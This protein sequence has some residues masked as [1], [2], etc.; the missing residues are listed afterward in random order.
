M[1]YHHC[2]CCDCRVPLLDEEEW[3]ML[4][5]YTENM[6]KKIR[7]YKAENGCGLKEA[8]VEIGKQVLRIFNELTGFNETNFLAVFHH[9]RSLFGGECFNC[10]HLL[11]T[12]KANYCANCGE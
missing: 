11:R 2:L 5:T 12:P 6:V 1:E 7:D 10:G 9:R 4:S 3:G 8:Q